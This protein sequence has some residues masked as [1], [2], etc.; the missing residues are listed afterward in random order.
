MIHIT[1]ENV[2]VVRLFFDLDYSESSHT[3]EDRPS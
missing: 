2:L 3:I 1:D